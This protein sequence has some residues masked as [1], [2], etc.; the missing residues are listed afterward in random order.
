VLDDELT[1]ACSEGAVRL[2]RL[3]RAGGKAMDAAEFQRGGRIAKGT[4]VG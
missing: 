1:I 4:K 2:T 3:Q